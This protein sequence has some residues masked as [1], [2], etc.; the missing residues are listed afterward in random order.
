MALFRHVLDI[1]T[2]TERWLSTILSTTT[3]GRTMTQQQKLIERIVARPPEADFNDVRRLL[4]IFDW[5]Q[6]RQ[7]GSH[8]TFV[9]QGQLPI[10][11]AMYQGRK[12]KRT[13]LDMICERL[14]L[15]K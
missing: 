10:V 5:T 3:V 6:A 9:K 2:L 4:E 11:V 15:E 7:R 13:Y 8:V 14:G 12:V 1:I